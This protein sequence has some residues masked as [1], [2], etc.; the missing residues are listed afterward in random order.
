LT[1]SDHHVVRAYLPGGT[2]DRPTVGYLG[3]VPEKYS[4]APWSLPWVGGLHPQVP[5]WDLGKGSSSWRFQEAK[6]VASDR[7]TCN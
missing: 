5:V 2:S 1:P 3:I 6:D 4:E 7:Y